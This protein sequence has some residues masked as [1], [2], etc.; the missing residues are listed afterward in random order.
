MGMNAIAY[1]STNREIVVF[2][3]KLKE[4]GEPAGLQ[5]PTDSTIASSGEP[6]SEA[7][8]RTGSDS[9]DDITEIEASLMNVQQRRKVTCLESDRLCRNLTNMMTL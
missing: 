2:Q 8:D 4:C 1:G 3:E 7:A 6:N 5:V 9:E